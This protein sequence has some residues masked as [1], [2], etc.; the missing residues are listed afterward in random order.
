V[1]S[2]ETPVVTLSRGRGTRFER[3]LVYRMPNLWLT[4]L[5]RL[6]IH[7]RMTAELAE[8]LRHLKLILERAPAEAQT[9]P[10]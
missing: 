3:E 5:D 9:Q 4:V 7:R 2:L 10:G 6:F 1:G 8:A